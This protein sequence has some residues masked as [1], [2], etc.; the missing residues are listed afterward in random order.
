MTSGWFDAKRL[1]SHEVY[2]NLI[3]TSYTLYILEYFP[4]MHT[5]LYPTGNVLIWMPD[6]AALYAVFADIQTDVLY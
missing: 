5:H 1:K 2:G 3:R 6:Y 4:C